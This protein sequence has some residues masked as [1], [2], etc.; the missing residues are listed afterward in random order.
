MPQ[1]KVSVIILSRNERHE[2]LDA[3]IAGVLRT[4]GE[5]PHEILVIDDGSDVPVHCAESGVTLLR[6]PEAIGIARAYR[7]GGLLATGDV[8]VWLDAHMSFSPGW[9]EQLLRHVDSGALLCSAFWKYDL[10][11][12]HC[13]GADFEWH[14]SRSSPQRYP[15]FAVRHRTRPESSGAIEVPMAIGGCYMMLRRSY[16]E[17][18]GFC[19]LFRVRGC[20]EQDLSA[21][22]WICGAGVRCVTEAR[23]GHLWRPHFP[24]P[25]QF[26]HLEFN[27][28]AL[29]RTV[30]EEETARLLEKCFKPY[31]AQIQ[32]WSA[33]TDFA[34][35][36]KITQAR[37][38]MSDADFFA[39]FAPPLGSFVAERA[40]LHSSGPAVCCA[41][42]HRIS[43]VVTARDE[44]QPVL[45]STI[46]G[47]LQTSEGLRREVIVVDDG[48]VVPVKLDRADVR[49]F[50][51][52]IPMGV[53]PS[54]RSGASL[55]NGDVLVWLDAHMSF[56]PDWLEQMLTHVESGALL[57]AAWW[58]YQLTHP[59]CWGAEFLWCNERDWKAGRSPGFSFRHCTEFRGTGAIE[60]PMV[61]GACYM[62]LRRNYELCGGYSPFFRVWGKS[63]QDISARAWIA[64]FGVKCITSAHV[65]HLTRPQFPYPVKWADIEFNQMAMVRSV[66]EDSVSRAI[67]KLMQPLPAEVEVWLSQVDFGDW[68]RLIQACR[69]MR[70]AE[71]FERFVP[72]APKGLIPLGTA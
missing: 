66:F 48:S 9:M 28:L 21:R 35:W 25:V 18:G 67:E 13:Y 33:E 50:R 30:F 63:E 16:E 10:S 64:G 55:A 57:C 27:Q 65:G 36:R 47:L 3:T 20:N 2:L 70:D 40:R 41:S 60:V 43:F 49:I 54:R 6:F 71:F 72:S 11:V 26:E 31:P 22:A 15:G 34:S 12:C 29:V 45:E 42:Q 37:R 68:R 51:N 8:L 5:R 56:A 4:T 69:K 1:H 59:I 58:D 38:H 62:M 23:V 53:T 52:S 61:M 7:T 19:P 17:L 24:Y 39:R 14:A 32:Q 44:P 46:E